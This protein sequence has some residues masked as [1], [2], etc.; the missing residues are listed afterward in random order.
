[1]PRGSRGSSRSRGGGGYDH[2]GGGHHQQQ[3]QQQQQQ[4]W[5]HDQAVRLL[6]DAKLATDA[7]AKVSL[8]KE[9]QELVLRKD[10][11]LLRVFLQPL[12]ELQVDPNTSVRK[13]IATLC[14]Q[15]GVNHPE[16]IA[17]CVAAI[18]TLLKDAVPMVR[19]RARTRARTRDSHG[20]NERERRG[21]W[22]AGRREGK[23][24]SHFFCVTLRP[25]GGGGG[26]RLRGCGIDV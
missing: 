13:T 23:T 11:T 16:Y 17:P 21:G 6:N 4:S 24:P 14:E 1:M 25:G 19:I 15:I 22:L 12:L 18:R 5:A 7:T 10:P 9:L 2:G 26:C 20:R 8:L 3:Q